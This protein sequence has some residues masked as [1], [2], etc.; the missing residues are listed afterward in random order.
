MAWFGRKPKIEQKSLASPDDLLLELFGAAP[1]ASG[2]AVSAEAA[3]KCPAVIAAIRVIS[4]AA[5][6]LPA[7]V[8]RDGQ[9]DDQHPAQALLSGDWNAWTSSFDGMRDLMKGCNPMR[10]DEYCAFR[11]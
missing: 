3:L 9:R 2:V 5:A 10:V 8:T 1:S 7:Y 11:P 4:E 6:T